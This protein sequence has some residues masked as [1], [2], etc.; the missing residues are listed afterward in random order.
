[1]NILQFT[2]EEHK[3]EYGL[4]DRVNQIIYTGT[5]DNETINGW[6]ERVSDDTRNAIR[7]K[8]ERLGHSYPDF[9]YSFCRLALDNIANYC[10]LPM[11]DICSLDNYARMNEPGTIGSPDWEYKMVNFEDFENRL[12]YLSEL[13][14]N[15]GRNN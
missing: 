11:Q 10:I 8:L 4:K 14:N 1:M 2:F 5:H 13:I 6:I 3:E 15:S 9:A 7:H 12:G